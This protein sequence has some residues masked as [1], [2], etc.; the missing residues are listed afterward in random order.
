MGLTYEQ[1]EEAGV[2]AWR[3]D[4]YLYVDGRLVRVRNSDPCSIDLHES[5][6][7]PETAKRHFPD[8]AWQHL[9]N[10]MCVFCSMGRAEPRPMSGCVT[11]SAR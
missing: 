7:C 9:P 1:V 11:R 8:R 4:G 5:L 10:C 2:F 3:R 6:M